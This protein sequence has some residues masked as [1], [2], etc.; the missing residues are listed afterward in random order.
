MSPRCQGGR[1]SGEGEGKGFLKVY[2]T[3]RKNEATNGSIAGLNNWLIAFYS[4]YDISIQV[5]K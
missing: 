5:R 4:T 3:R 1:A 2:R